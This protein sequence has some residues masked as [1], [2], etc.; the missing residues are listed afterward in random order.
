MKK[1]FSMQAGQYVFLHCPAISRLEWHPFTLTSVS[2]VQRQMLLPIK[3][4]V[5]ISSAACSRAACTSITGFITG[6]FREANQSWKQTICSKFTPFP[7]HLLW[8]N[9]HDKLKASTLTAFE[10]NCHCFAGSSGG[11][12]QCAHSNRGRLD[13]C[14]IQALLWWRGIQAVRR[15]AKVGHARRVKSSRFQHTY[16]TVY[17][18]LFSPELY[19]VAVDGPFGTASEDVFDYEVDILIGAGIGVT[20]FAGVLKDVW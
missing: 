1:D 3:R 18:R 13:K 11:L 7:F 12:L 15:I 9:S 8:I 10:N 20:P 4:L 17:S 6:A 19:R 16:L 14:V 2:Q 5:C